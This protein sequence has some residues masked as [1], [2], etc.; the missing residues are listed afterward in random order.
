MRFWN[1]RNTAQQAV[2]VRDGHLTEGADFHLFHAAGEDKE[3]EFV[4]QDPRGGTKRYTE[5]FGV[6]Q[7]KQKY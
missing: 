4:G 7:A 6:L 3:G 1:L 5:R 2:L